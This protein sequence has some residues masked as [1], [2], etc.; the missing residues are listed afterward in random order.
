MDSK[1]FAEENDLKLHRVRFTSSVNLT[2]DF[3]SLPNLEERINDVLQSVLA[4]CNSDGQIARSN[5]HSFTINGQL[6]VK[7][8]SLQGCDLNIF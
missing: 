8:S 2:E 3:E 7:V 5:D 6:L 1:Q 4:E